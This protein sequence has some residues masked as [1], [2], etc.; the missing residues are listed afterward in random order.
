MLMISAV[1][2]FYSWDFCLLNTGNSKIKLLSHVELHV[3][4][5]VSESLSETGKEPALKNSMRD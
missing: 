5:S 2:H 1:T 3:M 4:E